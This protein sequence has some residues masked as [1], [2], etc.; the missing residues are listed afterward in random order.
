MDDLIEQNIYKSLDSSNI[1]I[2]R[3]HFKLGVYNSKH[4]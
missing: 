3:K 1:K 2:E 4:P